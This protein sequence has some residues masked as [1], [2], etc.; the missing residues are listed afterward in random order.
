MA[1]VGRGFETIGSLA[2]R[3]G[4]T[5]MKSLGLWMLAWLPLAVFG[6]ETLELRVAEIVG[7]AWRA[8]AVA[9]RLELGDAG[10]PLAARIDIQRLTHEALAA[11]LRK[12]RVACAELHWRVQAIRCAQGTLDAQWLESVRGA[13]NFTFPLISN[14]PTLEIRDL[15]VAGG[16]TRLFYRSRPG[17]WV[18]ELDVRGLRFP[19]LGKLLAGLP[20]GTQWQGAGDL[21]IRLSGDETLKRGLVTGKLR[22]FLIA[23]PSGDQVG[24][25]VDATLD[26]RLRRKG[27]QWFSEGEL[28]LAKG[29]FYVAPFYYLHQ[30]Q[31]L[32]VDWRAAVDPDEWLARVTELRYRHPGVLALDADFSV[33]G[34]AAQPLR[35]ISL[36]LPPTEIAGIY[37]HYLRNWFAAMAYGELETSGT[38]SLSLQASEKN[39]SVEADFNQV[40]IRDLTDRFA[41][42]GLEG[43]LYWQ[44]REVPWRELP[45]ATWLQWEAARYGKV[46]V[47]LEKP[48]FL[49]LNAERARL[50]K[51]VEFG[52]FDGGVNISE[53]TLQ[54]ARDPEKRHLALSL[55]IQPISMQ[56]VTEALQLPK[57][58]GQLS[59]MIPKMELKGRE[60]TIGGALLL[61]LFGGNI[62]IHQLGIDDPLGA[63]PMVSAQ[64]NLSDLDLETLTRYFS[65][66]YISGKLGGYVK[67]LRMIHWQPIAFDAY[68]GTPDDASGRQVISQKAIENISNI[69]GS[70]AVNALSH[71]IMQAFEHF[72]YDKIG[73]G[74]VLRDG[75]CEMR[76]AE[77]TA[78]GYYLVKGWGLPRIDVMGFNQRVDWNTLLHRVQSAARAGAPVVK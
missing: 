19:R 11:P 69:G 20:K 27:A 30:G 64:L 22:D 15:T 4:G 41:L 58:G 65:F 51:P 43:K 28:R 17:E 63:V 29:E 56:A 76:G 5:R 14:H 16:K 38:L 74:C 10:G 18:A 31:P 66:G 59:G 47:R 24:Q 7:E 67:N 70:A 12:V 46:P 52:V 32:Q 62:V 50:F 60:F 49:L 75:I 6:A 39:Q 21:K 61:K 48:L 34:R 40:A 42:R 3:V 13:L 36:N 77:K 72:S 25:Q 26:T 45:N 53:F 33:D 2:R 57:L 23:N 78:N 8:E 44:S 68:L 71:Q 9:V 54:Q 35:R 73:W 1:E 55:D 37:Q